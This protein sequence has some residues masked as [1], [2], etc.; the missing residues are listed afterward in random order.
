MLSN[1]QVSGT[2]G[3]ATIKET[4]KSKKKRALVAAEAAEV[5]KHIRS[6]VTLRWDLVKMF[7]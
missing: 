7:R 2:K 4:Q 6:F 5:F 1:E 3:P